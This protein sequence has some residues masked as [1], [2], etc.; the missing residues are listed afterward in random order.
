[1]KN[2][3][4][5]DKTKDIPWTSFGR[6]T[7]AARVGRSLVP[8]GVYSFDLPPF[9]PAGA[10]VVNLTTPRNEDY[11]MN[12]VGT[13]IQAGDGKLVTCAHVDQ[14]LLNSQKK[15]KHYILARIHRKETVQVV[16]Y[17]IPV[18][19]PYFDIR[20][21]KPNPEVDLAVLLVPAKSIERLPYEVPS[22]RWGD[23]RNWASGIL[24]LLEDTLMAK[25]CS[26][27]LNL[28]AA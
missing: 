28:T 13:A 22:V 1:M 21:D 11:L 15:T 25:K 19:I 26:Y 4:S 18:S 12:I 2:P 24:S 9:N 17:P 16:P 7:P 23:S 14:A 27:S 20:T 8:V 10:P 6:E 3:K 5:Q